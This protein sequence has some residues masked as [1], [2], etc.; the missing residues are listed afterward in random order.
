ML[1]QHVLGPEALGAALARRPR[2]GAAGV[3][4]LPAGRQAARSSARADARTCPGRYNKFSLDIT[5]ALGAATRHG[6]DG[7]AEHELVVSV[8]DPA[9]T[10]RI[11]VGKQ[12]LFPPRHPAGIYYTSTSGI[13][14]TVW[15]E[16]VRVRGHDGS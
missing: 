13:W 9:D 6:A 8:W 16:P 14:Q 2:P 12:R 10:R 11:T 3:G 1:L 7:E 5:G 4:E 15:L